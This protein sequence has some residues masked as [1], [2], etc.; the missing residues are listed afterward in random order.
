MGV[1]RILAGILTTAGMFV[2]FVV[3]F[4]PVSVAMRLAGARPLL[5]APDKS[6]RT[7]WSEKTGKSYRPMDSQS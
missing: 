6:R 5:L 3:I 7:Y 1:L 2:L 4:T